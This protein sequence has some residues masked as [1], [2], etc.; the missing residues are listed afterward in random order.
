MPQWRMENGLKT[1]IAYAEP[2]V[3]F[4]QSLLIQSM[5]PLIMLCIC[6][7]AV[8]SALPSAGTEANSLILIGFYRNFLHATITANLS[9]VQELFF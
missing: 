1:L 8:K 3:V 5:K 7:S 9:R 6:E 2:V 4:P